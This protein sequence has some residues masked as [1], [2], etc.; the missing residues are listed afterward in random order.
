MSDIQAQIASASEKINLFGKQGNEKLARG[1]VNGM[2]RIVRDAKINAPK[3]RGIM[4][5]SITLTPVE[6]ED[7]KLVVRGGPTV[8][9]APN[10]EFGSSPH[11]SAEGSED[12]VASITLWGQR[13]GMDASQIGEL[14]E[15]IRKHGTKPHPFMGPA[16]YHNLRQIEEDIKRA[17]AE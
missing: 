6:Q 8:K 16:F 13:K 12:F 15:H 5:D 7:G 9:Y 17:M 4:A 3:D 11:T 1:L 10:V 14:I 2:L